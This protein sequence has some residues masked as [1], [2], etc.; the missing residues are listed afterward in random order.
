LQFVGRHAQLDQIER[1][2]FTK[3]QQPK[4]AITGLGGMGKTQIALELAYRTR[5]TYPDCSV[6]WVPAT[7]AEG[8]HQ[9]FTEI[10]QQLKVPGLEEHQADA[11][12]LVQQHLGQENAGRWLLIIDNI[13]DMAIWNS[14][15]KGC[16]PNSQQGCIICT[17]RNRKVAVKI[18]AANVVKVQEMDEETAMQLLSRSL[19][20]QELLV[21]HGDAQELLEQLTFLPLAIV[22]A[23]AYINENGIALSGYL[24]LLEEQE[25]DVVNLLS[26]DFEDD[27]RYPN[28]KNAVATTWLISFEQIQRLDPLAADYLSFMACIVPKNIP[29]SILPPGPSRKEETAAIGTLD[30]YSFVSK[31]ALD[32]TLEVHRLVQLATRNWLKSEDRW[33]VWLKKALVRLVGIVPLGGHEK[34]EAWTPYLPH[35]IYIV[36]LAELK[37]MDYTISLLDRIGRCEWELGRYEAATFT[38][39][40]L[41]ERRVKV[42]GKEHPETLVSMNEVGVALDGQGKH[43]EAEQMHR[44]TLALNE[45]VLGR[46]H[47]S[48]LVSMNRIG[49]ALDNQGKHAEAEQMH[50]K[51]LALREKV[52]GR[53]HPSTL[54]SMNEVGVA[55]SR[56]GKYAEAEQMHRTTLALKEK[57]L[58][59]EHPSTLV[60][61]NQLGVALDRQGK[62]AEAEQMHRKAL[63]L[64]EKA[65][66]KEHPE[67]LTCMHNLAHALKNQGRRA[68]AILL[69]QTCI[70]LRREVLGPQHPRTESSLRT[71]SKWRNEV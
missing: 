29:Q 47:P 41:L 64:R 2:L 57:V 19:I 24:S 6:L 10:G 31:P 48:T 23:A 30:A 62:H 37:E 61:M 70:Q 8:L 13:D 11:R 65:S 51:T 46:E 40:Q 3:N 69:L 49:I 35:A 45:K 12:K 67:T 1:A 20:E 53:E 22:Q 4:T 25:Q 43:V 7:N 42:L 54:K 52:L 33:H 17:T 36:G 34:R 55:L 21:H 58:G 63:A 14:E 50:R 44:K 60:S 39:M 26:E 27:G 9:A 28:I 5:D 32:N 18:A 66:G 15:L 59:K 56:Q 71:L 38:H 68:D 16:L